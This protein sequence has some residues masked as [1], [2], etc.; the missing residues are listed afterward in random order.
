M[1]AYL[2][3]EGIVA[4][5]KERGVD[6]I[7]PGYGFLSE[8][9][10]LPRACEAAGI[11]FM[12]PARICWICWAT[13]QRRG[14]WRRRPVSRWCP[15]PKSRS[16][17]TTT[18]TKSPKKS[19]IPL[20]VKAAFGGGGRG[21]RVVQNA[22][23]SAKRASRKRARKLARRLGTMLCF[24]SAIFAAPG[25][26]KFKFWPTGTETSCTCTSAIARCSGE[27]RK[28]WKSRPR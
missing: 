26:S 22:A 23:N 10:A 2:D 21:M 7:H 9:P 15:G 14:A 19:A 6:A 17:E 28:S 1:Q 16:R 5:A 20:I 4:M 3:V 8:N 11:T 13:R 12:G 27:I 18:R 24:W 25:I